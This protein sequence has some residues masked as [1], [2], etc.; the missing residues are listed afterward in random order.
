MRVSEAFY[1]DDPEGNGIEVYH[2]RPAESWQWTGNELKITTD[3]LDIDDILREV[4][5]TATF[6]GRA[7]RAAHRPRPS[8]GRRRRAR[9]D[10]LS[11]RARA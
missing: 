8:A 5:P 9:G 11:R 6:A 2:D 4:P 1:L 3:P 10:V 7:G